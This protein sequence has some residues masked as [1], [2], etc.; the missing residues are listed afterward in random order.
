MA[1]RQKLYAV[2]LLTVLLFGCSTES[3]KKNTTS[4]AHYTAQ[5]ESEIKANIAAYMEA[6]NHQDPVKLASFWAEDAVFNNPLTGDEFEGRD[7]I[8]EFFKRRF[9]SDKDD[10]LTITIDKIEFPASDEAHVK[11]HFQVLEGKSVKI[12]GKMQLEN[13]K[14]NGKWYISELSEFEKVPVASQFDKLKDLDWLVGKWSDESNSD[15]IEI[16]SEWKW[17]KHKNFL[18]ERF[19]IKV[20]GEDDFE[21]FQ[22]FAWDPAK[23]KIRSWVFDSD[24]GFGEGT[25]THTDNS[26]YAPMVYTLPDGSTATAT[27]IYTKENDHSYTFSS[28]DRDIGGTLL[29]NV[30]PFKIIKK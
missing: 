16:N 24:G 7:Q 11:S 9:E 1:L 21:G 10:R 17:D 5:D 22:M 30:G 13:I 12:S 2:S 25:L 4:Q 6:F 23:E 14:E 26:W 28:V 20:L 3:P 15:N 27:N 19:S 29:P 8:E 18:T